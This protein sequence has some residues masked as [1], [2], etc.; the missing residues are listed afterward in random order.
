MLLQGLEGAAGARRM[1]AGA[2]GVAHGGPVHLAVHAGQ[3]PA[4]RGRRP[5]GWRWG[6]PIQGAWPRILFLEKDL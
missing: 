6:F 1:F 5:A 2:R 4:T 3:A